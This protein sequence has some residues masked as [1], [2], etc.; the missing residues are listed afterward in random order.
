MHRFEVPLLDEL[1]PN[2]SYHIKCCDDDHPLPPLHRPRGTAGVATLWKKE[3]DQNI[4]QM[5]DG[6]KR[7]LVIKIKASQQDVTLINT[8]MPAE[9]TLDK[10]TSYEEVLDEVHEIIQNSQNTKIIWIGDMNAS[11]IRN[12]KSSNDKAFEHFCTEAYLTPSPLMPSLPTYHHFAHSS[13]SQIDLL[14]TPTNQT[15]LISKME[16]DARNPENASSHDAVIA[17]IEIGLSHREQEPT[18]RKRCYCEWK[19]NGRPTS[20]ASPYVKRM[21]EAK[22]LLRST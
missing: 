6:S 17:T 4:H 18:F 14:V 1:F 8:Y 13:T 10:T 3:H 9:G 12:R 16:I 5:P 19:Q 21:K 11:L 20:T 7:V 15:D 22:R 2:L